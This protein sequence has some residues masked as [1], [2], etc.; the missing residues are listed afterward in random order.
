MSALENAWLL[1]WRTDANTCEMEI[2]GYDSLLVITFIYPHGP[3]FLSLANRIIVPQASGTEWIQV[4]DYL[5]PLH[6]RLSS[7]EPDNHPPLLYR[8]SRSG[9]DLHHHHEAP[10]S[11]FGGGGGD[12]AYFRLLRHSLRTTAHCRGG[13]GNWPIRASLLPDGLVEA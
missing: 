9:S 7:F 13:R 12:P 10:K 6:W 5:L 4:D 11:I 3:S 1:K 2:C 8:Y